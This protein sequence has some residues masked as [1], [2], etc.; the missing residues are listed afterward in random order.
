MGRVAKQSFIN[1][2]NS[3]LGVVLGAFNTL[4][5]FPRIFIDNPDF[6]GEVNTLMAFATIAATFG[7]LGFPISIVSFFPRLNAQQKESFWTLSLLSSFI[8]SLLLISGTLAFN[9]FQPQWLGSSQTAILLIVGMLFFEVFAGLSQ[10]SSKVIFPQFLKNVF[11]RL[12]ILAA[13]IWAYFFHK[14]ESTFYLILGLGYILQLVAVLF[15]ARK[16]MPRLRWDFNIINTKDILKYG[17]LVM[18]ASGSLILVTKIDILMIRSM[19]GKSDVAFYNIAFFIGTVVAV[20][21]KALMVSIRPF[22]SKAWGRNDF[23]EVHNLYQRSALTQLVLTGFLF[24]FVWANLDLAFL[25]LPPKYQFEA[26]HAVVFCIGLSE[27]IKGATGTNGLILTLSNK[28]QYNF[29]TGIL[30]FGLTILSNYLLIPVLGLWGA[31][32]AS[33]AALSLFNII[34]VILVY[35]FFELL[36]F[37]KPF[38]VAALTISLALVALSLLKKVA[39]DLIVELAIANLFGLLCLALLYRYSS[40]L[41]DFKGIRLKKT[42]V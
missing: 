30:L 28:Q 2:I 9:W 40:A 8:G 10:N 35:R 32:L 41:N 26:F 3:Y 5:L 39:F 6:V 21:V 14:S 15:Y 23:K 24:I 22:M 19:L 12:I 38:W 25:I 7:H 11:R 13:L 36:P 31:A 34:K 42:K 20:P 18:L 1:S 17:L 29:Y 33:L 4:I 27:V 16:H 37:N